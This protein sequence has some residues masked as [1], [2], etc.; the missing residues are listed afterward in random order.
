MNIGAVGDGLPA[1][2]PLAISLIQNH[3]AQ[4]KI[5]F[6]VGI[7][8]DNLLLT[9]FI[10]IYV[11]IGIGVVHILGHNQM[12]LSAQKR[13]DELLLLQLLLI[14]SRRCHQTVGRH[15]LKIAAAKP[16]HIEQAE[17]NTYF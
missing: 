13:S 14:G 15:K 3:K 8:G 1:Q 7:E 12:F 2:K 10:Q 5:I 11:L 4:H 9:V 6:L 16:E 17:Q